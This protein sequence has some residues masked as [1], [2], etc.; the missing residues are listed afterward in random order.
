TEFQPQIIDLGDPASRGQ[1]AS[2]WPLV[3]FPVLQDD[4]RNRTVPETSIIIEYLQNHYPGPVRLLP[5]DAE[6]RLEARLWDRF[7]DLYVSLPVQ[8]IVGDRLRPEAN[9]DAHGVADARQTLITAYDMIERQLAKG[10]WAAGR[11]FTMA[12]CAAAPALFYGSILQPFG[13]QHR[14]VAAYF[15]RLVQRPSFARVLAE[16]RPYFE[17]FPYKEAMP[18]RFL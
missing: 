1:L 17:F 13:S 16:A 4:Q 11:D 8:R 18:K 14:A 5:E 3:K 15:E 6:A 9:R 2:L 10:V 7:F 12:D